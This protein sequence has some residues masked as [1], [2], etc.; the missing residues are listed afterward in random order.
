MSQYEIESLLTKSTSASEVLQWFG[1]THQNE[2]FV[3]KRYY[4]LSS[5]EDAKESPFAKHVIGPFRANSKAEAL[6]I[7]TKLVVD[8]YYTIR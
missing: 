8:K 2:T 3:I 6:A 4:N 5:I 1:Y 7:Y